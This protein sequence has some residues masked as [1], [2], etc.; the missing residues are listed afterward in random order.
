MALLRDGSR[1]VHNALLSMLPEGE[2]DAVRAR[3]TRVQL[4][5]GQILHEYGERIDQVFF[6][7][8]GIVS[9]T[10]ETDDNAGGIEVGMI[11]PEGAVGVTAVLDP[12]ATA[13][14]RSMVQVAG[15]GLRI[16]AS[17]LRDITAR[18]PVLRDVLG[19]NLQVILAQSS[20]TA[21]CNGR[22]TLSE[23]CA[24]W[25]L[26]AHDRLDGDELPLTQE[27]LSI[28]LAVRRPGVTVAMGT[29]Q[30]AGLIQ[31]R[32][33]RVTVLNRAGLEQAACDCHSRVRA[34]TAKVLEQ[35]E[36]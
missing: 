7:E 3:L 34:F 22:H 36:T 4:V 8:R 14:N 6:P 28:L 35:A 24:R 2:L 12:A 15:Q 33:G 30:T 5:Q 29:L 26:T 20:Q 1:A 9:L 13:F 19:R 18:S 25:L 16:P 17:D 21:A 11:G 27:F 23:R 32:R 31:Q 10:A